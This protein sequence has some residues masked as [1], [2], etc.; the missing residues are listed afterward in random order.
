MWKNIKG[1]EGRYMA[2][3]DGRIKSLVKKGC[4]SQN[5]SI[6]EGSPDKDGYLRVGIRDKNGKAKTAKIH[7]LVAETFIPNPENLPQVNH[8]NGVK[9]DNRVENLEWITN[10]DNIR[11]AVA[12]GLRDHH[13]QSRKVEI[14]DKETGEMFSFESMKDASLWLGHKRS[15]LARKVINKKSRTFEVGKFVIKIA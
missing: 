7:R 9:T 2:S 1:Y 13:Y 10:V 12:I 4:S 11:H 6:L 3:D 8:K 14:L 15:Y 5:E